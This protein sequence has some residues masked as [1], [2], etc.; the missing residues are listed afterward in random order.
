MCPLRP[1]GRHHLGAT[2]YICGLCHASRSRTPKI[3]SCKPD[4]IT[5]QRVE[6]VSWGLHGSIRRQ[7]LAVVDSSAGSV[8]LVGEGENP[9][10]SITPLGRWSQ[11][12]SNAAK[13]GNEV[14][15]TQKSLTRKNAN[16]R[17]QKPFERVTPI[18]AYH[19]TNIGT[20]KSKGVVVLFSYF[21]L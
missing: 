1:V 5:P 15:M 21:H 18:E 4:T 12:S 7:R 11:G 6:G 17:S 14:Q 16:I 13:T 20:R 19:H 10:P 3:K 2:T 8:F 9:T